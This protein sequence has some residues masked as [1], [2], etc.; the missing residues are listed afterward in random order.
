ML[1]TQPKTMAIRIQNSAYK[2]GVTDSQILEV[3]ADQ[4][5]TRFFEMHG[6]EDDEYQEMAVGFTQASVLLEI[7]VKYLENEEEEEEVVFHA[8]R[9][10][11]EYRQL[12]EGA[13]NDG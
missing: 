11:S 5:T 8:N 2:H 3:L 4:F 10:T 1:Y 13:F 9:V 6:G 7:G 12:F